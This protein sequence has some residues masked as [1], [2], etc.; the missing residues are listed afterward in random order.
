MRIAQISTLSTP[1]RREGSD[2]IES[3]VWLL[4]RELSRLGH[5][6][7]VFAA[8]GSEACGELVATLPGPCGTA[9]APDNWQLCELI[10]LCRAVE[11]S[12]RFDVLHSHAYLLGLPLERLARA[13]MVHTLH[14]CPYEDEACLWLQMPAAWV[15]AIS[16]YQWSAFP[17][18][19]PAA[20]IYHGV[21]QE[22]H[23]AG[24]EPEDYVCYLG[25][26]TPGK[27]PLQAIT[28]A[29]ALGLRLLLAGPRDDYY[30]EHV[31][32]Q[33]DGRRVEYVGY[34]SGQA[35][36]RLLRGARALLY[37][38]QDPEPFGLVQVEAMMCGTP[39]VAT[40]R[41]AVPEVIDEGVTGYC[42]ESPDEFARQVLRSFTLD[43]RR[44]RQRA[45]ERFAARQMAQQY[46][47]LY[48]QLVLDR[49]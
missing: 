28:A 36:D 24:L 37:P 20:V 40:R 33:V 22:Q 10:N 4:T 2:S 5:E 34:V 17:N 32:P 1:V 7:T 39:V 38:L 18:L 19:R 23:T 26:F 9:G 27:G 46:S 6:V 16:R 49:A 42:A 21:D 48:E 12:D 25:R 30:R 45:E 47:A 43:R 14:V 44:V 15:T 31:A 29:R 3:L 35:R 11:E 8:A 41:G 13:P